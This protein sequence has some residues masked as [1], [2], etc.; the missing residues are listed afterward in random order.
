MEVTVGGMDAVVEPSGTSL[1]RVT[2][3][4]VLNLWRAG[5]ARRGQKEIKARK[6]GDS[7][8]PFFTSW[9]PAQKRCG[10]DG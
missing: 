6:S 8:L 9:I 5:L 10:N 7:Q 3:M 2:G 4:I 1:R